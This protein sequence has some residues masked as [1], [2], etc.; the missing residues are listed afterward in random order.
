MVAA[1]LDQAERLSM[2]QHN[3]RWLSN[4]SIRLSPALLILGLI[5][6]HA[7]NNWIWLTKN[8]ASRGWDRMNALVN[9]LLY[10]ATLSPLSLH[11]LFKASIQDEVRPPL[12]AS[13][14]A[15]M[16]K[17]FG[18]STD[19]AVMVNVVYL[20][21]LVTA[22]YGV[23]KKLGGKG[24]GLL[25]AFL[26]LAFPLVFS[27]SR[28]SYFEFALTALV[29]LS[30]HFLLASERFQN[31][32]NTLF[33]GLVLGLGALLKRT[34]PVFVVGAALMVVLQAGLLQRLWARLRARPRPN[35]RDLGLA[36]GGG[37]LVSAVWYL[38]NWDLAQALPVG[39]WLFPIWWLLA[40]FT[41]YF[42]L[43]PSS[44][45]ANF[46]ACGG[47]G[48]FLASL[49]YVPHSNFVQ[50]ALRAGWGVDDP[51]GRTVGLL[52]LAT[53]T[54]YLKSV[55]SGV[56]LVYV[57][58]LFLAAA[59]LAIY[60]LWRRPRLNLGRWLHSNWLVIAAAVIVPYVILSTS[61]YK[62]DRAVTPILPFLGVIL[63]AML[64][65]LP[66]RPLRIALIVLAVTFGL[67]Q[68][69]A[70]SYTEAYW[71][72]DKT[73][74]KAPLLGQG[75]LFDQ[76]PYVEVPDSGP[77]DPGF[78][79]VSDVLRSVED[80][81]LREGWETISLG[82]MAGSDH[83]HASMFAYDQ[84]L[85]YPVIRLE[86]PLQTYPVD[87]PYSIAF[88]YDY[89]VVLERGN[90]GK[91]MREGV[92]LILNQRRPYFEQAFELETSYPL[93]DGDTAY[94]LRRRYRPSD[95]YDKDTLYDVA[96]HLGQAAAEDDLGV[97]LGACSARDCLR[98]ECHLPGVGAGSASS[99]ARL[100]A[101]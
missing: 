78:W 16:Y 96:Q 75:G 15:L 50:R 64:L 73:R 76:G 40:A 43:P 28:Y 26:V 2:T 94:L 22:S 7:I 12:Y 8:V 101:W 83:I 37:L 57:V 13:S 99:F 72:V 80:T 87:S 84:I 86:N 44:V 92:D 33:L 5:L 54:E 11:A 36:I 9:S 95:A 66:G 100:C 48:V 46:L 71:L 18:V 32:R 41:I 91:T 14:M 85:Y 23:G 35:W 97:L 98:P 69:F 21:L 29:V 34:Y 45:E 1:K 61:I 31:R 81:R 82:V 58:L 6:F 90:R 70:V 62:E 47:L 77:N 19:V 56:S 68:F 30:V 24:L 3:S 88:R 53:Y 60:W 65:K 4:W 89:L 59:L 63:A 27:M 51:R 42:L 74:F 17:F 52:S 10:Y 55:V 38:P 79:I 39:S 67:V 93:P 20:A 49:W 25:S